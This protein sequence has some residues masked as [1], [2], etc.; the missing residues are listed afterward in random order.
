MIGSQQDQTDQAPPIH[1]GGAEPGNWEREQLEK[2][3]SSTLLETRRARRWGIFFKFLTFSYLFILL[4]I[5]WPGGLSTDSLKK[6]GHTALVEVAGIIAAD[7]SASADSIVTGLRAA[8]EDENTKG[9]ILRINSPGGS[10]VQAGYIND[11]IGRL[12]AKYPDIPV[13]AVIADVCAS[14]GYY[15]AVAADKIYANKS[16]IVGSIG[17]LMNSFGFVESMEKL[18]IERRLLTAGAHKGIMDPF[19]P[20]KKEEQEHMQGMLDQI[21]QQF[22]GVVKAGR[23][24]R[25]KGGDELFSGLFWSGEESVKLGLIDGLGSSSFVAREIIG[26]EDIVDFTPTENFLDRLAKQVGVG[27]ANTLARLSGLG[28]ELQL[29]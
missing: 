7:Q 21:H 5:M 22:I 24:D 29:R 14:G 8:F 19:S 12:K 28:W 20:M 26:A 10:P 3:V 23:G 17:V 16:S 4:V 15:I 6:D 1:S 13:Y 2:L 25:L 11:E 9:V 18:G 27:A